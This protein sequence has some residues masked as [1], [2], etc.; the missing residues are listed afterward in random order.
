[1]N[2]SR[3][4]DCDENSTIIPCKSVHPTRLKDALTRDEIPR[5]RYYSGFRRG[6][7]PRRVAPSTR[8]CRRGSST[9]GL[10]GLPTPVERGGGG[11]GEK[12]RGRRAA[13]RLEGGTPGVAAQPA[14]PSKAPASLEP[15]KRIPDDDDDNAARPR[16][17]HA[18]ARCVTNSVPVDHRAPTPTP[19][20]HSF[21]SRRRRASTESG[22]FERVKVAARCIETYS[23]I[24]R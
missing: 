13:E 10:Q 5:A 23:R 7:S 1:M 15:A 14:A 24:A 19:G 9:Q 11:C 4:R 2:R 21:A 20:A 16:V 6:R 3:I 12:A 18:V 17:V 22:T 8:P